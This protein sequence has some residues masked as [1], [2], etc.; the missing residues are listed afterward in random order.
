MDNPGQVLQAMS[1]ASRTFGVDTPVTPPRTGDEGNETHFSEYSLHFKMAL[2][3]RGCHRGWAGGWT[4]ALGLS[5]P[6]LLCQ[7]RPETGGG[8]S[9][10]RSSRPVKQTGGR[11][12]GVANRGLRTGGWR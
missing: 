12:P 6:R 8:K 3:P 2:V 4:L 7:V 10:G 1:R 11:K 5:L 9:G